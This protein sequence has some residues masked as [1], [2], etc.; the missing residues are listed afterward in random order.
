V[1]DLA[2]KGDSNRAGE[3]HLRFGINCFLRIVPPSSFVLLI[4]FLTT[5]LW[6]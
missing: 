5:Y 1:V 3:V 4:F 2:K 6:I